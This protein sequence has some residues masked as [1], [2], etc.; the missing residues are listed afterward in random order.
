MARRGSRKILKAAL[1]YGG[2]GCRVI[3]LSGKKPYLKGWP[4][5]A[6]SDEGTIR[7]WWKKFPNANVGIVTGR[8]SDLLV[9]DVD[10]KGGKRGLRTLNELEAR[11]GHLPQS[12]R[13]QTPN[14]MHIYFKCPDTIIGNSVGTLG[15]GVDIRGERGYVVAPPSIINGVRYKW[16]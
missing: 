2:Q 7:G 13:V 5:A 6:S 15:E 3:P 14:G 8:A 9:I 4:E 1:A 12:Q 16:I 11:L 10:E